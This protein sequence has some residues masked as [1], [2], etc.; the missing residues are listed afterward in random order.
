MQHPLFVKIYLVD[1]VHLMEE[2]VET[3][4]RIFANFCSLRKKDA[5]L[6]CE[7]TAASAKSK[8]AATFCNAMFFRE[9]VTGGRKDIFS[10]L[11]R[12]EICNFFLFLPKAFSQQQTT[13]VVSSF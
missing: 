6:E 5:V 4:T 13:C 12:A 9:H 8:F 11:L 10:L 1:K 3:K 2:G 7:L